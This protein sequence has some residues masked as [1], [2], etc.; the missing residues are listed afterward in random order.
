M[1]SDADL[2]NEVRRQLEE[3]AG[4]PSRLTPEPSGLLSEKRCDA[5]GRSC[6]MRH[7]IRLPPTV[8]FHIDFRAHLAACMEEYEGA[9]FSALDFFS[10]DA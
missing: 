5:R 3:L 6:L 4:T 8:V 10:Q 7:N 9:I 1:H 2:E